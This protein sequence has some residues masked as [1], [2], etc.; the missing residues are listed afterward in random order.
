ML[1]KRVRT[2][3]D[4]LQGLNKANSALTQTYPEGTLGTIVI[5]L[6]E[7]HTW[8]GFEPDTAPNEYVPVTEDMV[9]EVEDGTE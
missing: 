3:V 9:E 4:G 2:V 7:D 5:P 1:Q 8:W 6:D